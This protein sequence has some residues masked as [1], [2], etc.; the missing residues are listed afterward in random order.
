[1]L[2]EFT[3]ENYQIVWVVAKLCVVVAVLVALSR[4]RMG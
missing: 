4:A 3:V 1:V 2:A